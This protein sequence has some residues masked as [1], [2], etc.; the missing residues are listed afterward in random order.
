MEGPVTVA[1]L[2]VEADAK[3]SV[4]EIC[5]I[6]VIEPHDEDFVSSMQCQIYSLEFGS[7]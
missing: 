1:V 3:A 6:Q 7:L 4:P 5:K 2:A